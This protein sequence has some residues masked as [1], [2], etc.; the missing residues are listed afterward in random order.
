MKKWK[1]KSNYEKDSNIVDVLLANRGITDTKRKEDFLNP[2]KITDVVAALPQE[3][4]R[5]LLDAKKLILDQIAA[6]KKIIIYGDYDADG[7]CSTA[8]LYN[9]IQTEL[10]YNC[11]YFI[12][13]RFSNGYGLSVGAIDELRKKFPEEDILFITVDTGITAEKEVVYI[14]SLGHKIIITDHHQKPA[15]LPP[16]DLIVWNDQMVASSIS[17]IVSRA[18]G[19]KDSQSLALAAVAT[20][21]DLQ[22]LLGFNRTIVTEGLKILNSKP[23]L[24]IKKLIDVSSKPGKETS[25]YDLGYVIGPRLN[26]TGRL[27][28]AS[29]S[30][31]LLIESD[32]TRIGQIA[33][34][35]HS[36]NTLRQDKTLEMYQVATF[37]EG[38]AIPR[39]IISQSTEYHEGIIGLV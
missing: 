13:N 37:A 22:P 26:A 2:P 3:F 39:I 28:S 16:A 27:D 25:T 9:T 24:G 30:L 10:K 7:V 32:E 5:S 21:T 36:A 34:N 17:W 1:I 4:R 14:K 18:L 8:I 6:G 29:E 31:E 35:L 20:V 12:P 33:Q 15:A 19:S 23:P 11:E 38:A